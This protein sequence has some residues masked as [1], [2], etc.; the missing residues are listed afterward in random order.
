MRRHLLVRFMTVTCLA[1]GLLSAPAQAH[2]AP[3]L[4]AVIVQPPFSG[5]WDRFGL[6]GASY[7]HR[8]FGGDWSVDVYRAPASTVRVRAWPESRQGSVAYFVRE[9]RQS[10]CRDPA[11]WAGKAVKVEFHYGGHNVGYAWYAHLDNVQVRALTWI[12]H[13][14][15]LGYTGRYPRTRC[16]DVSNDSGTHVHFELASNRHY[17]CYIRRA[18]NAWIDYWGAVG[19]IGGQYAVTYGQGCP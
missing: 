6:A 13:G 1:S 7:H 17:A 9:V 3:S 4:P 16:Y 11:N 10:S 19:K 2:H 5:S 18:P 12:P 14:A 8:P 15:L